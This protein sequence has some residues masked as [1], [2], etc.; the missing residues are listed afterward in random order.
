MPDEDDAL[1]VILHRF[2]SPN[3]HRHI[4]KSLA[5]LAD[6]TPSMLA[7]LAPGEAFLW[8]NRATHGRQSTAAL[9]VQPYR[10]KAAWRG[11]KGAG[12][13]PAPAILRP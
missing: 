7:S 11:I 1:A 10:V 9:R 3:C 8:A 13:G 6:L 4:Q 2:N 5:A 12:I